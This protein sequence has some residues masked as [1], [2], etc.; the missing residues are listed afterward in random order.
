MK[1]SKDGL[2]AAN[3]ILRE[4]GAVPSEAAEGDGRPH[5]IL[6]GPNKPLKDFAEALGELIGER[7]LFRRDLL[8]VYPYLEGGRLE[9]M[10]E[11]PFR[12]WSEERIRFYKMKGRGEEVWRSFET[13]NVETARGVLRAPCFVQYLPTI[14][15]VNTV[16]CPVLREDGALELL[17]GG[18]DAQSRSYTFCPPGVAIDESMTFEVARAELA[19][20]FREFPFADG[21][22]GADGDWE[23]SRSRAVSIAAMLTLFCRGMLDL[24][25]RPPGFIF[26]GNS[27]GSG[28]SLAAKIGIYTVCGQANETAWARQD[29]EMLKTLVALTKEG[30][31]YV[32]FDNVKCMLSS[33]ALEGFMTAPFFGGR[34]LGGNERF[35]GSNAAVVFISGND[36]KVSTDISRRALFVD[37]FVEQADVQ[38]REVARVIDEH[39]LAL[40]ANRSRILSAMWALVRHWDEAGRPEV[41]RTLKGFDGWS[42]IIP[43]IVAAA[44]FGDCLEK[45]VL[46]TAGDNELADMNALVGLA[47][48]EELSDGSTE[49]IRAESL[50]SKGLEALARQHGL[51]NW[52]VGEDEL[53]SKEKIRWGKMLAKYNGRVFQIPDGARVRFG[54]RGGKNRRV[55]DVERIAGPGSE[56]P[57]PGEQGEAPPF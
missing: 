28:K 33:A 57:P 43:G 4:A 18:Y 1:R 40:P 23:S 24:R 41:G 8:P 44:G 31:P 50:D 39:W 52:L 9:M 3:Q 6:P 10:A 22:R 42:R 54:R 29:E 17:A 56:L 7:G 2:E 15:R 51:F 53:K 14:E 37:L 25:H 11:Q 45:P 46:E 48:T 32:F 35:Y 12:T 55:F 49:P 36:A 26:T 27:Q 19:G 38:E 47:V 5:L 16:P 30:D 13:M 34:L 21:A 20:L